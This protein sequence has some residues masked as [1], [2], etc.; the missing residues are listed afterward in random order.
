MRTLSIVVP[1]KDE[2]ENV[3]P[4]YRQVKD[5]LRDSFAWEVV[6]VDDGSTDGTFDELTR[7]AT[8][9]VRVKVVRLRRNFGQA[10]A[11]QAGIDAASG[12][13]VAT[14]DGDLQNDPAD[15]PLLVAKLDEGYD[16]VLGERAKRRDNALRTV[17]SKVA[18][19]LI[20]KVT[21]IPFRDFGCTLR[22]IRSDVARNLRIY[23]EMHR[24]IPVLANN[25]GARMAQIPVRH[26]PRRA[27]K[28]KYG[29]GRTGRVLLDL[30]TIRF[31][32]GYLTRPMHFMGGLGLLFFLLAFVSL[33]ATIVMKA[34]NRQWMTGNPL[35][36]L[37]V[38]L[39]LVGTQ[40]LSMGLL[41]EV[42]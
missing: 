35:L 12:E 6:Y 27:G 3:D 20:R 15:I 36:Y 26:H 14:M 1:V 10:A 24:F 23:G 31:M 2:R 17:V 5:V 22:V 8:L 7:L 40:M 11:M 16:M 9:D 25:I 33:G 18:N 34:V 28:S 21:Q 42:M 38:A 4:L 41:G 29:F 13:L 30:L 19:A 39:G 37:S 32:S